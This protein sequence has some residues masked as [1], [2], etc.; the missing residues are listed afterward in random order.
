MRFFFFCD[1]F[2]S[3][4][5]WLRSMQMGTPTC[6]NEALILLN[7]KVPDSWF[8]SG[9]SHNL[10]CIIAQGDDAIKLHLCPLGLFWE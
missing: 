10:D 5:F 7:E 1:L 8:I 9:Q 6:V 2:I 4:S 3:P